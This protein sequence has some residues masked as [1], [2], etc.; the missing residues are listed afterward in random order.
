MAAFA[1]GG[2]I[3]RRRAG[4]VFPH[5]PVGRRLDRGQFQLAGGPPPGVPS[6]DEIA[7]LADK[8]GGLAVAAQQIH[9]I[10]QVH[11]QPGNRGGHAEGNAGAVGIRHAARR[12][13]A[14]DAKM[15]PPALDLQADPF[16]VALSH[17]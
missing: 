15:N 13:H 5:D 6:L 16:A 3:C 11:A 1:G 4:A 9:A 7:G 8:N 10:A 14:A 12:L 2:N 17:P